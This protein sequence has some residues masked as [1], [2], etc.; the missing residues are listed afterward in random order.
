MD[1]R[2]MRFGYRFAFNGLE[3]DNEVKG[4]GNSY[5]TEYRI[6]DSRLGRWLSL[7]PLADNY[8]S[9]SPYHHTFNNPIVFKDQKGDVGVPGAL[10]AAAFE[11]AGQMI[12]NSISGEPLSKI[13]W[14]DVAIAS[15]FVGV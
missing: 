12:A 6:Y 1:K 7:D 11:I 9:Y 3:Q 14:G 10:W 5:T 8:A 2:L 15:G 4:F 13:D